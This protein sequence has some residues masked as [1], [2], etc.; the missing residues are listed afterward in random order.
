MSSDL[1]IAKTGIRLY[2]I[3]T[4]LNSRCSTLTDKAYHRY[5]GRGVKV[6]WESFDDFYNDMASTHDFS[7]SLDRIDNNGNYS[8]ENCRWATPKEQANNRRTNRYI[9]ANGLRLTISQ[10]AEHLGIRVNTLNNR[11]NKWGWDEI[12]AVTTPPRKWS[13]R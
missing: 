5:G 1:D 3:W 11:L 10:W 8:K 2:G 6:E 9:E 7:L 12:K 4:K 13:K